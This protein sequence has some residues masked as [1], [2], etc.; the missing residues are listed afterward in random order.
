MQKLERPELVQAQ[1][2][3]EAA[4]DEACTADVHKA[5]TGKLIRIAES[6]AIAS[7]AASA[8]VSVRHRLRQERELEKLA[9]K[10]APQNYRR[11]SDPRG[12]LWSAF[13]VHPSSATGAHTAL[14]R[15][16]R[17]GWLSFDSDTET[18]RIAPI[19]EGWKELS[20]D[21]LR[22]LWEKAEIARRRKR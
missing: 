14:P 17:E 13:A 22:Q 1:E 6:L 3:L 10:T 15:Q 2:K 9:R 8:A 11:F 18:R 7:A 12:I 4:L 20:E 5:D 21:D 16:Y 19:P